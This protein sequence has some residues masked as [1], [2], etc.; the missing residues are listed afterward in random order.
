[1]LRY[2]IEEEEIPSN[3]QCNLFH[4]IPNITYRS[5][6]EFINSTKSCHPDD[7]FINYLSFIYCT[8]ADSTLPNLWPLPLCLVILWLLFLLN[9]LSLVADDFLCPTLTAIH[10]QLGLS[11]NLVGVTFVA[12][13]NGAPDIFG[14][15]AALDG[16]RPE[17]GLA[18]GALFG[19]G[20]F[21]TTVV[22]GAI[23]IIKPFHPMERPLLRDVV[24]YIATVAWAFSVLY[25]SRVDI[26]DAV[27][28]ILL[29]IVYVI[30][31]VVGRRIN[32]YL[33]RKQVLANH[34]SS[35]TS[36][37]APDFHR[38]SILGGGDPR[39]NAAPDFP[40][41]GWETGC[42]DSYPP[43]LVRRNDYP[44]VSVVSS[45]GPPSREKHEE[46]DPLLD[47][48]TSSSE[49]E[50]CAGS[51]DG[52]DE[53]LLNPGTNGPVASVNHSVDD[54]NNIASVSTTTSSTDCSSVAFSLLG[55]TTV[56][57]KESSCIERIY[58]ISSS[59][60]KFVFTVTVPL[61]ECDEDN[62]LTGW[63]QPLF[64]V[65]MLL[66]PVVV[67]SCL[68]FATVPVTNNSSVPIIVIAAIAGFMAAVFIVASTRDDETPKLFKLTP[69]LGFAMSVLW[70]YTLADEIVGIL[71]AVGIVAD[72]DAAVLGLTVLAWG[73]SIGDLITDCALAKAGNSRMALSACFAAPLF[74][75]LL[76]FG[77]PFTVSI[78]QDGHPFSFERTDINALLIA[79]LALSLVITLLWMVLSKFSVGR[80]YGFTLVALYALFLLLSLLDLLDVIKFQFSAIIG[81]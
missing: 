7:G 1:M 3:A 42:D 32:V 53:A 23:A 71:R 28:F 18:F 40:E 38:D 59:P 48:S 21:V 41:G 49:R 43:S 69:Y 33:R 6:C 17:A 67:V 9:G 15:I 29:Y 27:G 37:A 52:K 36:I 2:L 35:V 77:L 72:I 63:S 25:R 54:N 22:V 10:R 24:F 65:Q 5:I 45:E 58:L 8:F 55:Q 60:L 75:T 74:N 61:V 57:W 66:L 12:F 51:D 31:V 79:T 16:D 30:V 19:A 64:A 44:S 68:D 78:L 26:Y 56:G 80:C 14:S 39:V 34:I 13:G 62:V 4:Q 73:N 46:D 50:D 20:I 81:N 11:E 47:V 76:G 70:I